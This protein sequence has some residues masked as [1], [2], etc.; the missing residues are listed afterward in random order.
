M[1]IVLNLLWLILAGIWMAIAYV[2][3]GAILCITIIGIPFGCAVVQTGWLR[4]LAVRPRTCAHAETRMRGLSAGRQHP[5]VHP[6]GRRLALVTVH[7]GPARITI[8][9]IPLGV[10]SFKM[11]GAALV[12][13]GK[14]VV[15]LSALAQPPSGRRRR[16][17]GRGRSIVLCQPGRTLTIVG[18][19]VCPP[20]PASAFLSPD[21]QRGYFFRAD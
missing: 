3:A 17:R 1:R 5:L 18:T 14:E 6:C 9:G 7:R 8:I 19:S 11:A 4:A 20:L 21:V 13:F 12:P 10:A 16:S 2:L 15:S